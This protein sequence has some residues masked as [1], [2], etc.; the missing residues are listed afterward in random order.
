MP[1]HYFFQFRKS[2]LIKALA[3]KSNVMLGEIT[4]RR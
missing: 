3:Q 1:P 2:D 4:I